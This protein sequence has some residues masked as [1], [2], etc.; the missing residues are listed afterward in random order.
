MRIKREFKKHGYFW[1][2]SAPDKKFPGTLSVSDGGIIDLEIVEL[3]ESVD[4]YDLG[5]ERWFWDILNWEPTFKNHFKRIVGHIE[6]SEVTLDGCKF[7]AGNSY[8]RTGLSKSLL[9]VDRVFTGIKYDRDEIPRFKI[10]IF[11]LDGINE[12]IG[13]REF[14]VEKRVQGKHIS[15][16]HPEEVS[17]NLAN[18]MELSISFNQVR[19]GSRAP[20]EDRITQS[21]YFKL[22]SQGA[23]ELDEFVSVVEKIITFLSFAIGHIICLDSIE[24]TS[25]NPPPLPPIQEDIGYDRIGLLPINIFYSSQLYSEDK[26]RIGF[27]TL[28]KYERIQ[29]DAERIICNWVNAYEQIAPAFDLYFLAQMRTQPSLEATFLM[30]T[31]GLEVFH[32]RTSDEMHMDEAEFKKIRKTLVNECPKTERDW[33][34]QKLN[35]ANELTLKNRIERMIELFDYFIDDERRP[36]L[37][38]S[39]KDTRNY[40]THYDSDLESKAAKGQDLHILCLKI[41]AL[42]QL[43]FLK[44]IGFNDQEIN[45]IAHEYSNIKRNFDL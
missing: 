9:R 4:S 15:F 1:L 28:F 35:Y 7:N 22:V 8:D 3:F 39:I 11:S 33:F 2:P 14:D 16:Q 26:T 17:F 40:L 31:T 45:D 41:E 13:D 5:G 10:L 29:N 18:G 20:R 6:T 37:I 30:L 38:D 34:A 42:F 32:R 24:A 27:N 23:R 21:T 43:H 12:W 44:L 36:E 25:K 19:S